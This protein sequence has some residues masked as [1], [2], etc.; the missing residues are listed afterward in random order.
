LGDFR[1]VSLIATPLISS[2]LNLKTETENHSEYKNKN[3]ENVVS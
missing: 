2:F 1:L 3:W